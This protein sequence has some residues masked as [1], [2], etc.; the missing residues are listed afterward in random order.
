MSALDLLAGA[1]PVFLSEN[2]IN[3]FADDAGD[4]VAS[5]GQDFVHRLYDMVPS[6]VFA[7]LE[8][9]DLDEETIEGRFHDEGGQVTRQVDFFAVLNHNLKHYKVEFSNDD[10]ETWPYSYEYND[11]SDSNRRTSLSSRIDA[12]KWRLRMYTVQDSGD[13]PPDQN[14]RVGGL[15]FALATHQGA[16]MSSYEPQTDDNVMTGEMADGSKRSA[17]LDRADDGHEFYRAKVAMIVETREE[18]DILR[19]IKRSA[20][21]LWLPEPGDEPG[22]VYLC[23]MAPGSYRDPYLAGRRELGFSVQFEV[24]ELGGC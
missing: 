13:S 20:Q 4:I 16:Q 19:E 23:R 2:F 9:S 11:D 5:D 7:T 15:V 1:A 12:N 8:S 14:K 17:T 22:E 3:R 24:E 21:F 10:G 18:R 6:S